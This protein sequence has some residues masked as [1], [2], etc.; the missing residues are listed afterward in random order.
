MSRIRSRRRSRTRRKAVN[1][2]AQSRFDKRHGVA[3]IELALCLPVLVLILLA[4]VETCVMIQLRQNLA[5]TAYEGARVGILP[6]TEASTVDSQCQ[7]LLDDR[8]I[9]G[10][11]V[12]MDPSDPTTMDE[13]DSFRVTIDV[14][15]AANSVF[16]GMMFQGKTLSESVVM[17]AE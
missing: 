17:K 9:Q 8:N 7:M 13:G 3:V 16:G 10:Y 15:C 4:T 5:I 14:D 6:G 11:S 12:T 1:Q 2:L